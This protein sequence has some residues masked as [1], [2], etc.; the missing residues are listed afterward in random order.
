MAETTNEP[1]TW[2]RY[3]KPVSEPSMTRRE[4]IAMHLYAGMLSCCSSDGEF[5]GRGCADQAVR[6]ADLLIEQLDK[7]VEA[8]AETS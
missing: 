7:K 5:A 1:G 6:E 4:I 2:K 3:Y 8:E